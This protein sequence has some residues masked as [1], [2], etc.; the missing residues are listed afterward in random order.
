MIISYDLLKNT[1]EL[2]S[3]SLLTDDAPDDF[4]P[5]RDG[6]Y[7][8]VVYQYCGLKD[9]RNSCEGWWGSCMLVAECQLVW[10]CPD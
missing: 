4:W 8:A 6:D 3:L 7:L 2:W 5:R 10:V 9:R 1:C